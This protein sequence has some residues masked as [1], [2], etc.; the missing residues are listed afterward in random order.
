MLPKQ[1]LDTV[2]YFHPEMHKGKVLLMTGGSNGGMLSEICKS[3][4]RHGAKAVY[5]MARKADK[6]NAVVA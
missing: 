5:L 6:L 3:Y 1:A 2:N 4:L